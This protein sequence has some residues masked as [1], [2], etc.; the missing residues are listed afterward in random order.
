M[1]LFQT[2]L[3]STDESDVSSNSD[4]KRSPTIIDLFC[5]CGGLACG[6]RA[7]GFKSVFALDIDGP[8]AETYRRNFKHNVF[9]NDIAELKKIEIEADVVVGGPPCQGFSPLGKMSPSEAVAK[10]HVGLNS[11]WRHYLRIVDMVNPKIFVVENVP[12]ILRSGEYVLLQQEAERRGYRIVSGV[13][14]AADYGVPQQRRRAFIIASRV[15]E[16]H[17]PKPNGLRATVRNAIGDL[18]LT[19]TGRDWHIGRNPT[20]MSMERYKC[21]PPG[22]N[23]FDLVRKR[24]DLSPECW[25]KKKT[26][27]TDVFGRLEWDKPSLTIRTEFFKPE[28]GRYLHPQAHRPIT[29]REAMRLQTFPDDFEFFG[30]KIQVARQVGNAVPPRLAEAVAKAVL[31]ILRGSVSQAKEPSQVVESVVAPKKQSGEGEQIEPATP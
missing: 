25:I 2:V 8:A 6:F 19:P 7:S 24:P 31:D 17:L 21:I 28:K 12:E 18:P 16:P 9:D 15:G 3:I 29:H 13:L 1:S 26:G 20:S 10:R 27:S 5:G 4:S 30:T 14:N 23:R 22:G 11:L